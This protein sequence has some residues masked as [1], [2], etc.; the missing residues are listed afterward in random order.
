MPLLIYATNITCASITH[1]IGGRLAI[2]RQKCECIPSQVAVS[3]KHERQ[4][5]Y[6]LTSK[7]N[8]MNKIN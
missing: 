3:T 4:M 7:R 6:D 8:L 5:P 2:N 1:S